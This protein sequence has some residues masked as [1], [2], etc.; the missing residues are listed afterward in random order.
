M[1]LAIIA[2]DDGSI[3]TANQASGTRRT[4][5]RRFRNADVGCAPSRVHFI[6]RKATETRRVVT[7]DGWVDGR[8]VSRS[9]GRAV[10]CAACDGGEPSPSGMSVGDGGCRRKHDMTSDG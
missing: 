6:E 5:S 7:W 10:G 3:R 1:R 8:P 4:R 2:D 9:V